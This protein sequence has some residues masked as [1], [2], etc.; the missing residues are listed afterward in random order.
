M[1]SYLVLARKYRPQNFSELVGQEVLVK[2]LTNAIKNNRLHHAYILHGIRGVGKTTTARIIAKTL[3]CLN[4][5]TRFN[6]EACGTCKNC[7]AISNSHHQDVFEIDA[8]S[9][10]GV[11]DVREII[12]SV[13]YAPVEARYKIYIIDEFHMMS[14]SAFNALLK[15]LEEP[16]VNVKFIFATTEIREVPQTILSRCQRFNLRRLDESEIIDHLKNILLKEGFEAEEQALNLIAKSSEGSVRDAL[17]ILD[18]ALANNNHQNFL[19]SLVIE[20]ML[21][22]SDRFAI[23]ELLENFLKGDVKMAHKNF[24]NIFQNSSDVE[25]VGKDLLELI[26]KILSIKLIND[27]QIDAF[28]KSQFDKL[29]Y[30]A[31][32][33]DI[34]DLIRIWQ[35]ISKSMSDI[36]NSSSSK[37]Y[38]EMLI[39]R[40]CHLIAIPDLKQVLIN[41]HQ[42]KS[43]ISSTTNSEN[44]EIDSQE[45][46]KPNDLKIAD[47]SELIAQILKNFEGSRI[48]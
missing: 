14:D 44:I 41:I 29:K 26:H 9:R 36:S 48:V 24:A 38:F 34:S 39:I 1:S 23:I 2:T 21:G 35:L 3:N 22:L 17:S 40:I 16:P 6:G 4:D 20:Q 32:N 27:Y 12:D 28:S 7:V 5:E 33:T 11:G 37:M 43:S 8:A 19:P 13:A 47:N 45:L 15:T 31:E 46:H 42:K 25:Q 10:T 18:Q 30:I